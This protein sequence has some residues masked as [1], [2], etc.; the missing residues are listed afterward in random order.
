MLT[1]TPLVHRE[2]V[3]AEWAR[4]CE[5]RVPAFCAA[6][7]SR[8][9][10]RELSRGTLG[11]DLLR[12]AVNVFFAPVWLGTQVLALILK[13]LRL[14][15]LAAL[16]RR[17][18]SGWETRHQQRLRARIMND[19]LSPLPDWPDAHAVVDDN[20]RRYFAARNALGEITAN[21]V[22]LGSGVWLF[23]SLTPG[24][25]GWGFEMA[26]SVHREVRIQQFWAGET[27]GH[28]WF[29]WFEPRAPLLLSS[30]SIAIALLGIAVTAA[31]AGRWLD[32]L[33]YHCGWQQRRMRRLIRHMAREMEGANARSWAPAEPFLARIFDVLDWL[34]F[35]R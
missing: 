11:V 21:L 20:L 13:P 16:L 27:L 24:G 29:G 6:V 7:F 9:G 35:G 19:L 33:Q 14:T 30:A 1:D 4:C 22:V 31:L 34:R 23:H 17:C 18:P 32:P 2:D 25:L 8:P 26:Q 12:A 10:A 15:R 3:R 5:A 28:W